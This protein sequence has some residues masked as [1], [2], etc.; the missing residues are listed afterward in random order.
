MRPGHDRALDATNDE[1]G[2][3]LEGA[4]T[5]R[6]LAT[7]VDNSTALL[8]DRAAGMTQLE[9]AEA[10]N[11][12]RD[13]VQRIEEDGTDTKGLGGNQEPPKPLVLPDSFAERRRGKVGGD[14]QDRLTDVSRDTIG[15]DLIDPDP[16]QPR[17]RFDTGALDELVASIR[18][19]GLAVPILL[20]PSG[21]RFVIV[22]GERRW[23]AFRQLGLSSIPAEVRDLD[24]EAARWLQ[25]VENITRDDLGPLEE[26]RAYRD[27]LDG[28]LTQQQL[29]D[30][31]GKTR[32]YIA[33]KLRLLNLPAPSTLLL[34][35]GALTEGHA[36]QLLRIRGMYTDSHVIGRTKVTPDSVEA[37]WSDSPPGS[38]GRRGLVIDTLREC[39]PV[40]WPLCYPFDSTGH[41]IIEDAAEALWVEIATVGSEYPRWAL[42]AF[43]YAALTIRGGLSVAA[44]SK[45]IDGWIEQVHSAIIGIMI[46]GKAMP[47]DRESSKWSEWW[48]YRSD[49]R[50]AGLL[51]EHS[52][53]SPDDLMYLWAGDPLVPS[54]CAGTGPYRDDYRQRI[55][56]ETATQ[57][58]AAG[59]R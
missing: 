13:T 35:A 2:N 58:I 44:L 34:D 36:R 51:E 49:L 8:A 24:P 4:E 3:G 11:V 9:A 22:H 57:T 32:T 20:R 59:A 28:G 55:E 29:A 7:V 23:R 12:S 53:I 43:Y 27:A 41:P 14:S 25:L 40:D 10:N 50:H 37:M 15:L 30:R 21:D 39:R 47:V 56:R 42:P 54:G 45:A 18:H 26:A 1:G 38:D 5:S 6:S 19:N 52:H 46:T 31:I 33:Q 17:Q 48:G 16:D